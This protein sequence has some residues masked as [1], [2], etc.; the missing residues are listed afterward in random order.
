MAETE[1][2]SPIDRYFRARAS[3]ASEGVEGLAEMLLKKD[4]IAQEKQHAKEWKEK[5]LSKPTSNDQKELKRIQDEHNQANME[6]KASS[7][8][9]AVL[10]KGKEHFQE[11]QVI[12]AN[13]GTQAPEWLHVEEILQSSEA[14]EFAARIAELPGELRE[15]PN[16]LFHEAAKL[17]WSVDWS[18]SPPEA[19]REV[20][21]ILDR[22]FSEIDRLAKAN[23]LDFGETP[24]DTLLEG[25]DHSVARVHLKTITDAEIAARPRDEQDQVKHLQNTVDT[26]Q[27]IF[28]LPQ[29]QSLENQREQLENLINNLSTGTV[30]DHVQYNRKE[31]IAYIASAQARKNRLDMHIESQKH[32][33]FKDFTGSGQE[34][35]AEVDKYHGRIGVSEQKQIKDRFNSPAFKD[36]DRKEFVAEVK[37]N[38]RLVMQQLESDDDH[39]WALRP[40]FSQNERELNEYFDLLNAVDF[41]EGKKMIQE[42]DARSFEHGVVRSIRTSASPQFGEA[43]EFIAKY[44]ELADVGYFDAITRLPGV[45]QALQML[46]QN[47]E[48]LIASENTGKR[49]EIIQEILKKMRTD[50]SKP[51]KQARS[52]MDQEGVTR[53]AALRLAERHF[54]L[55]GRD[56]EHYKEFLHKHNLIEYVKD[57]HGHRIG[58]VKETAPMF[59]NFFRLLYS[60]EAQITFFHMGADMTGGKVALWRNGQVIK[61]VQAGTGV[62]AEVVYSLFKNHFSLDLDDFYSRR[63]K[64]GYL[65]NAW[66]WELFDGKNKGTTDSYGQF[67]KLNEIKKILNPG[68]ESD[69]D[70]LHDIWYSEAED[71]NRLAGENAKSLTPAETEFR[72][73]ERIYLHAKVGED[74]AI[75]M[76]MTETERTVFME[77]RDELLD[78]VFLIKKDD[79]LRDKAVGDVIENFYGKHTGVVKWEGIE[80]PD[81]FDEWNK[82]K[83]KLN[84]VLDSSTIDQKMKEEIK[85]AIKDLDDRFTVMQKCQKAFNNK[86]IGYDDKGKYVPGLG[87]TDHVK[88]PR[89]DNMEGVTGY[90]EEQF[91]DLSKADLSKMPHTRILRQAEVARGNMRDHVTGLNVLMKML[92]F[93]G[94]PSLQNFNQF[95]IKDSTAYM[96]PGLAQAH[97]IVPA[98]EALCDV[99]RGNLPFGWELYSIPQTR[100]KYGQVYHV[101][102]LTDAALYKFGLTQVSR[103][104]LTMDQLIQVRGGRLK[105]I[106]EELGRNVDFGLMA[107]VLFAAIQKQLEKME[108]EEK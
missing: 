61:D 82:Q 75:K 56:G 93:V 3:K 4:R 77:K 10:D 45:S 96:P 74:F 21:A 79:P 18:G 39:D 95:D 8:T 80:K 57:P 47:A 101:K 34:F 16:V 85:K 48:R 50:K 15:D 88:G 63:H 103:G 92:N 22:T 9:K 90:E 98:Y 5:T 76:G 7:Y 87:N 41:N 42:I 19:R 59:W 46:E 44:G 97:V 102:S 83:K 17:Y 84:D 28:D 2:L 40:G 49:E 25:I 26:Y 1:S 64:G 31:T 107:V 73:L 100:S 89:V 53:E 105:H 66:G 20:R 29:N 78:D 104:N 13:K 51:F 32:V 37:K 99:Q 65:V 69:F 81:E 52:R 68:A 72:A 30:G 67:G 70:D 108:K 36:K 86:V 11:A 54:M 14:A 106:G 12:L 60:P 62:G 94:N 35:F 38:I 91:M 55:S 6:I 24:R 58:V 71:G 23:H 27:E 43:R 33:D